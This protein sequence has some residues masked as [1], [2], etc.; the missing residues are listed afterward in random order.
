[1]NCST[2]PGWNGKKDYMVARPNSCIIYLT[3]VANL[4]KE[5]Y[6]SF[7]YL[8]DKST[9][10]YFEFSVTNQMCQTQ[11]DE[12]K[13]L[14]RSSDWILETKKL[15]PGLNFLTWKII[16]LGSYTDALQHSIFIQSIEITGLAFVSECTDCPAG[17][18]SDRSKSRE[19]KL[20]PK[21]TYSNNLG[22]RSCKGCEPDSYSYEGPIKCIK[23]Q[24]CK[25][26]DYKMIDP[27]CENVSF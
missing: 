20:C 15:K 22:S 1:M 2:S 21:N 18:Y 27:I 10:A 16:P 14:R 26:E 25:D 24:P 9:T 13:L 23:K 8:F 6:V 5:G 7:R 3:Y 17:T 11:N 12:L 4:V 19:C